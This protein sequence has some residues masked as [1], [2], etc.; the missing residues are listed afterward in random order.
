MMPPDLIER[1]RNRALRTISS[2]YTRQYLPETV[3][4]PSGRFGIWA[5]ASELFRP[6]D[7]V[8][9][10]P[11]TCHTVIESLLA[12][13]VVPAF[14]D[15]ELQTGNI[16]VGRLSSRMLRE[17]RG[18]ITTNLYGN[19]DDAAHLRLLA[20]RWKICLIEDCAHVLRTTVNRRPIGS[21]GDVSVFSFKKY[22]GQAGG[23]VALRDHSLAEKLASRTARRSASPA[24]REEVG[25]MAQ[26]WIE[27]G[28][29]PEASRTLVRLGRRGHP[30]EPPSS[31]LSFPAVRSTERQPDRGH[32][33]FPTAAA[34]LRVSDSLSRHEEIFHS[35][36]SATQELIRASRLQPLRSARAEEVCYMVVPFWTAKRNEWISRLKARGIPTYFTYSPPMNQ[37]FSSGVRSDYVTADRVRIW[38]DHVLP[39]D[40]RHRCEFVQEIGRPCR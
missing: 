39:V 24:F 5:V 33:T 23:I 4:V 20:D 7:Q 21:F 13:G 18:I 15:I 6:G 11:L 36:V 28:L 14:V 10:S 22:F 26:Y 17:A 37:A 31:L 35:R 16:D 30:K 3:A 8:L 40:V 38:C 1:T 27:R 2:F 29:G 12:A 19:P 25:R 9:I 32:S 34:L